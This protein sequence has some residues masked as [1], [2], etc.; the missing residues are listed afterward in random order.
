MVEEITQE[1]REKRAEVARINLDSNYITGLAAS[2][3]GTPANYG[4][5]LD[6]VYRSTVS[7]VPDEN[8]YNQLFVPA[9]LNSESGVSINKAYLETTAAS[10]V[11]Q[12]LLV[13]PADEILQ[14]IGVSE[15]VTTKYSG[16]IVSELTD[17]EK[18][19]IIGTYFPNMVEQVIA[20][21]LPAMREA[22]AGALERTLSGEE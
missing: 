10:I 17:E 16:K 22:R 13:L 7:E 12:S 6:G 15:E 18:Q 9:L 20:E 5:L 14:A 4:M 11:Q 8:T 1:E 3:L 21:R 19:A 2:K